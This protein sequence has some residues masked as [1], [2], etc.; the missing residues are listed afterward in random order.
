MMGSVQATIDWRTAAPEELD[1]HRCIIR[2]ADGTI[3]DGW[4]HAIPPFTPD[5]QTTRFTL[6]DTD[7]CLGQLRILSVSPKHGTAILQ[8]HI[9]SLTVTRQ[10]KQPTN[11]RNPQ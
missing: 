1:G 10:T 6:D 7:L 5:Y 3:I 4:L 11:E 8:P 9:R 2:T